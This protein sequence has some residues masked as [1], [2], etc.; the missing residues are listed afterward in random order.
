MLTATESAILA[1]IL[2]AAFIDTCRAHGV[3]VA[4][5]ESMRDASDDALSALPE[6]IGAT[7]GA[8]TEGEAHAALLSYRMVRDLPAE[9]AAYDADMLAH[10]DALAERYAPH[11][12]A[13][14]ELMNATGEEPSDD[15]VGMVRDASASELADWE[16]DLAARVGLDTAAFADAL[17]PLEAAAFNRESETA[18]ALL[19]ALLSPE[20]AAVFT[21][22]T[23]DPRGETDGGA[24]A[25]AWSDESVGLFRAP[26]YMGGGWYVFGNQDNKETDCT[27]AGGALDV[28]KA[29]SII[30]ARLADIKPR[31][32]AAKPRAEAENARSMAH[33]AA[34]SL[35]PRAAEILARVNAAL[36]DAE[37][38]WGPADYG[39]LMH[40]VRA[41]ADARILAAR[42]N[43][44]AE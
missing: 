6:R 27:A 25:W 32:I 33:A 15:D 36:Q 41:E 35:T 7:H 13:L 22:D 12:R 19:R 4:E 17:R 21:L 37:E 40:A 38:I 20:Y 29:R 44:S 3:P 14:L 34:A 2:W 16:S 31:A 30:A 1:R 23:A 43:G 39:R 28:E 8:H 26:S 10:C 11:V 5:L 18:H 24:E 9:R 42:A